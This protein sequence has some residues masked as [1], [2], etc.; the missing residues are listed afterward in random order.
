[1]TNFAKGNRIMWEYFEK[2]WCFS[3][4]PQAEWWTTAHPLWVSGLALSTGRATSITKRDRNIWRAWTRDLVPI[5]LNLQRGTWCL[6]LHRRRWKLRWKRNGKGKERSD[7]AS[8]YLKYHPEQ[9]VGALK[10]NESPKEEEEDASPWDDP[11]IAQMLPY[12]NP[13]WEYRQLGRHIVKH[14]IQ[15][16]GEGVDDK[17]IPTYPNVLIVTCLSEKR[18]VAFIVPAFGPKPMFRF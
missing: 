15:S 6:L 17:R 5:M 8:P 14:S 10:G 13:L 2:Q 9:Q 11:F 16:A 3:L 12:G 7:R 1:L 4:Y 18:G